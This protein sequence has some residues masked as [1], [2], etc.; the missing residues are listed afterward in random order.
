MMH[1]QK[2][3]KL[4][5]PMFDYQICFLVSSYSQAPILIRIQSSITLFCLQR[6]DTPNK[7]ALWHNRTLATKSQITHLSVKSCL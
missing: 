7:V 4:Y 1:G 5:T 3:I 2:N 6:P